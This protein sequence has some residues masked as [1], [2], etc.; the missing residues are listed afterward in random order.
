MRKINFNVAVLFLSL[1]PGITHADI[2]IAVESIDLT[3]PGNERLASIIPN[4]FGPAATKLTVNPSGLAPELSPSYAELDIAA[5]TL[6]LNV[7][8]SGTILNS[9]VF[10]S[11]NIN[12][13]TLQNTTPSAITLPSSA[14]QIDFDST[15]AASGPPSGSGIGT[16][17]RNA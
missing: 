9:Q 3:I 5:A 12:R 13:F 16:G 14:F 11:G 10:A 15:H 4:P 7:I 1:L 8:D 6:K 17:E 2:E